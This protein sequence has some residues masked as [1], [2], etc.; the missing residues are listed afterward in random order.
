MRVN[1]MSLKL[2]KKMHDMYQKYAW[3]AYEPLL[4]LV[5][6]YNDKNRE[7]PE[8][9]IFGDSVMERVADDDVD[10][11]PLH[12]MI[13]DSLLPRYHC[14]SISYSA[15][16]PKIYYYF[17]KSLEKLKKYPKIIVLP[18]NIRA[19]SPQWDLRPHWQH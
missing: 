2:R 8:I 19:F 3:T 18:I 17:V 1:K 10:R 15:Y 9:L 16:N 4:N 5:T 13:K 7:A 11:R 6:N 14:I 12:Q